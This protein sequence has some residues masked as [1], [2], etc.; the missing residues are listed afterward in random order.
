MA[1]ASVL[2]PNALDPFSGAS[3][4][5]D[6]PFEPLPDIILRSSDSV[7]FHC[8]KA[9]LAHA[10]PF[11]SDM[12]G[13]ASGNEDIHK[14]GTV[15]IPLVEPSSVLY[16]LLP[17]VYP[18]HTSRPFSLTDPADLN[19]I[20]AVHEA[21]NKYQM[22][23]TQGLIED[24]LLNSPLL[25]AHPHRFFAIGSIR[26]IN[27]LVRKAALCTL[28]DT[29]NPVIPFI[30]EFEAI[31][32]N[33]AIELVNFLH[34]C[35]QRAQALSS[36]TVSVH[37]EM[38]TRWEDYPT[39]PTHRA[40]N[41]QP[42]VWW[43]AQGHADHCGSMPEREGGVWT[44]EVLPPQWYRTHVRQVANTLRLVPNGRTARTAALDVAPAERAAITA[45][46]A[47]AQDA[48]HD[49]AYFGEQ[50]EVIINQSNE[51]VA[52]EIWKPETVTNN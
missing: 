17:R 29:A 30:P 25:D 51:E 8:H 14:N 19:D 2:V 3:V 23:R 27:P 47:C 37:S 1:E 42:L 41:S 48:L 50:L 11:F 52:D 38:I 16:G 21:A 39:V 31:T 49:L 5:P 44:Q 33:R 9:I 43:R 26:N 32:G 36:S 4:S 13:A 46:P 10:S 40:A 22:V 7:D 18:A 6:D 24:M 12:F 15:V 34:R 45:C 20:L 35:G 28:R